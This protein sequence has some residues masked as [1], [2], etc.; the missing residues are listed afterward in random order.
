MSVTVRF[1]DVLWKILPKWLSDRSGKEPKTPGNVGFRYVWT[2]VAILD[3]G[4]EYL[5]QGIQSWYPGL[6]TPTALPY[7][8]RSRG[9]IQG[10][11][12]ANEDFAARLENWRD[13]WDLAGSAEVIA[14]TIHEYLGNHPRVRVVNR[15]G[16]WVTV[17]ADGT[18]ERTQAAWDWDSV[19]HPERNDP[20]APFWSEIFVIV[21]PSQW[22]VRPGDWGSFSFGDDGRGF[23]HLCSHGEVDAVKGLL[24]QWKSAHTL[25]RCVIWTTDD[26]LFDPDVPATCPDGTWGAWSYSPTGPGG[27]RVASGRNP[28]CRYWEPR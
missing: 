4:A 10:Q 26:T 2:L 16:D 14:R 6:G 18:V 1:R 22:T 19:S 9:L 25:V 5:V 7:I 3:A 12:E 21:S 28:D 24:S 17:N 13:Y 8:G 15:S 20:L 23:G 27:S 11:G